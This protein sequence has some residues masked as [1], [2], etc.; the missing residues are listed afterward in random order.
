VTACDQA[1]SAEPTG[2]LSQD[3]AKKE[4]CIAGAHFG[5]NEAAGSLSHR[6][7][8]RAIAVMAMI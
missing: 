5:M 4:Q 6:T 1:G 2:D 3:W 7:G 8:A